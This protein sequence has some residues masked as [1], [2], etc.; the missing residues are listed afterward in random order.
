MTWQILA[1]GMFFLI[2][3]FTGIWMRNLG[4][5]LNTIISTIH[6]LS[7]LGTVV[8]TAIIIYDLFRAVEATYLEY[9]LASFA[10]LSTLVLVISGTVL[11]LEKYTDMRVLLAHKVATILTLAA[12]AGTIYLLV[13]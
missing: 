1:P 6:K 7:A 3:V 13:N 12:S 11:A 5:P 9:A 8:Y 4:R 10:V 2:T